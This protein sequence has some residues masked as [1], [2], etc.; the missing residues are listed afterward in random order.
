MNPGI[1]LPPVVRVPQ[2]DGTV[3]SDN[4]PS[5]ESLLDR[6]LGSCEKF[7]PSTAICLII[8]AGRGGYHAVLSRRCPFLGSW[9][10]QKI[11]TTAWPR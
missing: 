1:A 4:E 6:S 7:K 5:S 3:Y 11:T 10:I 2:T 9:Q 8:G